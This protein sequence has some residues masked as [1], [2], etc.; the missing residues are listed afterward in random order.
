MHRSVTAARGGPVALLLLLLVLLATACS[1]PS[2]QSATQDSAGSTAAGATGDS[3]RAP[4]ANAAVDKLA[5]QQ[6]VTEQRDVISTGRIELS[7]GDVSATRT[8]LD[9]ALALLDGRVAD[10]NTST[11]DHGTVTSSHLVIRVPS[12]RFDRAMTQLAAAGSLRSSSRK[13]ED[14]TTQVIDLGARIAAE[15]AGVRRLR[16]LVTH[17]ANLRALLAVERALTQRQGEL[18]SLRQQQ[19][20]LSDRT[21]LATIT[22]DVTRTVGVAPVQRTTGGFVGGLRHGWHAFV[23]VVV[24]LLVGVGAALPFVVAIALLGLPSWL[25]AR[26]VLRTKRLRAP[27][28]S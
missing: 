2:S 27:A 23:T 11:N 1:A 24:G 13:A 18:E 9:A 10:E 12:S 17:T 22:V 19:A 28:E 20:Y 6:T 14:V 3:A 21:S 25:V 8:R 4:L 16:V 26:R 15:R 5:V 7:S